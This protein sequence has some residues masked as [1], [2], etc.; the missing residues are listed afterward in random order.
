MQVH[1]K[2]RLIQTIPVKRIEQLNIVSKYM[3]GNGSQAFWQIVDIQRK[4]EGPKDR[5]LWNSSS[6]V[7]GLRYKVMYADTL[8]SIREITT[9]KTNRRGLKAE[10]IRQFRE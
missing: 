2:D 9:D 5:N 6:I 1:L 7:Q 10:F 3:V 8:K 4:K